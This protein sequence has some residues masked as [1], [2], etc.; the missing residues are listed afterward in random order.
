MEFDTANKICDALSD[1]KCIKEHNDLEVYSS[2]KGVLK[3]F[4]ENQAWMVFPGDIF[5]PGEPGA[6]FFKTKEEAILHIRELLL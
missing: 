1:F 6:G 2:S 5:K 3:L 4:G